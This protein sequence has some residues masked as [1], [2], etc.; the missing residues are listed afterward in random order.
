MLQGYSRICYRYLHNT[1][2]SRKTD[3]VEALVEAIFSP[4]P[5]AFLFV[6]FDIIFL[7]LVG[8]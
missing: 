4:Y 5:S 2:S 3:W 6:I 1:C 7:V 8:Q